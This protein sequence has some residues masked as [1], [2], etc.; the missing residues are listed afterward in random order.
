MNNPEDIVAF[1]EF[2]TSNNQQVQT[3][4]SISYVSIENAH[5]NIEKETENKS[6]DAVYKETYQKWN[7]LLSRIKVEGG[8]KDDKTIFY[9]A[10]YHT[11]IHPNTLND[12]NGEYPEIKTGKIGKTEGTRYTVFSLWDTYRAL[13][14]LFNITQPERNNDMIKS[15]LAHHDD[16]VHNMLPIWSQYANEN[17]CMIGYHATS[18]IADAM[19]KSV[20]D[21]SHERALQASVNTANVRYFDGLGE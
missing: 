6:F 17:W 1:I 19:A 15:M 11:L 2:A 7:E 3:R 5:K 20:G 10:L 21:F 9:T 4:V 8:S 12:V 14:P 16:S 13:H 18:V